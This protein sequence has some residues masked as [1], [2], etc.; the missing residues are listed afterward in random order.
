MKKQLLIIILII[1][2]RLLLAQLS[3]IV[4]FDQTWT[5]LSGGAFTTPLSYQFTYSTDSILIDGLYYHERL[6]SWN[7]DGTAPFSQGYYREDNGQVFKKSDINVTEILV[8]DMNLMQGDTFFL[9]FNN[10]TVTLVDT[11]VLEDNS[12][13]KRILLSCSENPQ[14]HPTIQWI[15]GIGEVL[16]LDPYCALD[17]YSGELVCVADTN[18]TIYQNENHD[19]CWLSPPPCNN[20]EYTIGDSWTYETYYYVVSTPLVQ[21]IEYTVIDTSSYLG[22]TVYQLN[23]TPLFYFNDD[24]MYFWDDGLDTF[25]LYFDFK[26]TEDYSIKYYD[27]FSGEIEYA[28][29]EIDSIYTAMIDGKLIGA[30]DIRVYNSQSHPE[31][32]EGTVYENIGLSF[33]GPLLDLDCGLCDPVEFVKDL[34]CISKNDCH[35]NFKGYECDSTFTITSA[36]EIDDVNTKVYPNPASN[37]LIIESSITPININI[38]GIDGTLILSTVGKDEIDISQLELG[39]YFVQMQYLNGQKTSRFV[40]I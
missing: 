17:N 35:I 27:Q 18:Q 40:K 37:T 10:L 15:E 14:D 11:I 12:L 24:K 39:I 30:Q 1:S 9:E 5:S 16:Y 26:T 8:L 13:R 36:K 28:Q 31:G 21:F 32:W 29:I 33:N 7:E 25:M 19:D 34:R 38:I 22:N 23:E 20:S 3:P 6:T 2:S 4:T